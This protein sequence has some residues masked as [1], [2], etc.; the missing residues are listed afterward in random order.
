MSGG[1]RQAS[2][3]LLFL[4]LGGLLA[5]S[6][7][8]KG[9]YQFD[10][11]AT[12]LDDSASQ[13]VKAWARNLRLTLRP[14][15]KLTFALEADAGLT[16]R[17]AVRRGVSLALLAAAA[18]LLFLLLARL[19]NDAAP[20]VAALLAALWFLHP[21]HADSVLMIGGRTAVLATLFLLGAL[22]ALERGRALTA[23]A[24]FLLACLSRETA[25][26]GLLPL[27]VLATGR[28]DG[29]HRAALRVLAPALVGGLVMLVWL[30]VTP[31]YR[32]LAEFSF[33]GR[34][35]AQSL[36]AQVGAVPRGLE[37][38]LR[39]SQLSIDY[40]VRLP[41]AATDP[42]F[43]T[44]VILYLFAAAGVLYFAK[45]SPTAALGLALWLAALVPTQS[46]IPKLDALSN[47]P[48]GL[49]LAGLMI[50]VAPVFAGAGCAGPWAAGGRWPTAWPGRLA[51]AGALLAAAVLA[52][53]TA[54]RSE[55]FASELTLW[56]DAAGKAVVNP[57]PHLQYAILLKDAGRDREAWNEISTARRIDPFSPRIDDLYR[58][59]KTENNRP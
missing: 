58:A 2:V 4:L 56:A 29:G 15:A 17:P 10:D 52:R 57:R 22:L 42:L 49:A 16:E 43:V 8:L 31:R 27:A 9:P 40:G 30:A 12:P 1:Q 21:V 44:G 20:W 3:L 6:P 33:L 26:A 28:A 37:V 46:F 39:P 5:W 18:V 54:Q 32:A 51:F 23:G 50:T 7:G 53:A 35:L 45:R 34:P 11:F 55:L 13:S 25:L 48:L 24:L 36:F 19:Q 59:W 38:L 47:R 41:T 14:L